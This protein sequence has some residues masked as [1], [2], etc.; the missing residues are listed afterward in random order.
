MS[1]TESQ[2]PRRARWPVA[3][4]AA[5]AVAYA[6]P[7]FLQ[8]LGIQGADPYR[9]NDWL[10]I[11]AL[12]RW[13][14]VALHDFGQF[15]LWCTHLGGG[16]PTVQHPSDLSLT[17]LALPV[18]LFGEVV[19]IKIDLAVLVFLGGLGMLLLARESLGLG[20]WGA[21]FSA[22]AFQ[23]SGWLPSMMLVGFFN[24]A[25]YQLIP[26]IL[27]FLI[28][29]SVGKL[30]WGHTVL[31]MFTGLGFVLCFMNGIASWSRIL[32]IG[33]ELFVFVQRLN[34]F[35]SIAW[36]IV[37]AG[38]LIRPKDWMRILGLGA[39]FLQVM[40]GTPLAVETTIELGRFSLFSIAPIVSLIL[41]FVLLSPARFQRITGA[42]PEELAVA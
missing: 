21:T 2:Q 40:V 7:M 38:I 3:V 19:G 41:F 26:L 20:P 15:P 25:V 31:G 30:S 39:A 23:A 29:K 36:G 10:S 14:H 9:N 1:Q 12:A 24:L 4:V 27:Y 6:V 37:T 34:W 28:M 35:S 22:V 17:P 18:V 11:L 5:V 16:Y 13:L 32:T 42:Q 8:P 33:T